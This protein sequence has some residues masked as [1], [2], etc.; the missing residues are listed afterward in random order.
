[1]ER[2]RGTRK[3]SGGRPKGVTLGAGIGMI[4]GAA[5]GMAATGL[6][7]GAAAGLAG[8]FGRDHYTS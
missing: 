7:L 8:A 6:V 2:Y 5:F 3:G 1:M 4:F